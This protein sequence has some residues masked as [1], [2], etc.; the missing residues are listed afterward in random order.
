MPPPRASPAMPTVGHDPPG[1]RSPC[2]AKSLYTSINSVP[3][4][5]VTIPWPAAEPAIV[6]VHGDTLQA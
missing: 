1:S 4:P 6:A 2:A 5:T 3:A